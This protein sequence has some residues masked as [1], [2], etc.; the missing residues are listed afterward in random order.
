LRHQTRVQFCCS[1]VTGKTATPIG[2]EEEL[3]PSR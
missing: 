2:A 1:G 3:I